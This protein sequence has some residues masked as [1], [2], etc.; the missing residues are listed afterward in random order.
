M[1]RIYI[2]LKSVIVILYPVFLMKQIFFI[3][4]II[5]CGSCLADQIRFEYVDLE[6]G[7]SQNSVYCMI[8][9]RQGFLLFGR[10]FIPGISLPVLR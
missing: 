8:Q 10:I 7:L 2:A 5:I 1:V 4:I 9:D 6:A 3:I